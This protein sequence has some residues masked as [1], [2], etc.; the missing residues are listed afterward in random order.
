LVSVPT[1]NYLV[2][3]TIHGNQ[4]V[5]GRGEV[6]VRGTSIMTE[7]YRAAD[8]TKDALDA[9]GFY[10]SGDVGVMLPNGTLKIVDRV[11]NIF[12]LSIGECAFRPNVFASGIDAAPGLDVAMEKVEN[13]IC[14]APLVA[15][16]FVHGD[17]LHAY[18]VAV[19]VPD[20]DTSLP[21]A[22]ERG[23]EADSLAALC[24][25][26]AFKDAVLKQISMVGRDNGLLGF[27]IPQKI[28]LEPVPFGPENILTPTFK[29]QRS[30][31]KA[32]YAKVLAEMLGAPA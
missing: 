4:P 6:C 18:L 19:V 30:V 11:R 32:V 12:K 17:S 5:I 23:I 22:K 8:A 14:R 25:N 21:W 26:A 10:H 9:D 3:D 24:S 27:E 28:H 13:Q 31:A 15:Q 16:A 7:Y 1:M 2:T 29:M 20:G